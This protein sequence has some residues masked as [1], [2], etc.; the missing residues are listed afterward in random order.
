LFFIFGLFYDFIWW[1]RVNFINGLTVV[2]P[3]DAKITEK[4][5]SKELEASIVEKW[6]NENK[7]AFKKIGKQDYRMKILPQ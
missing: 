5:W 7:Y 4:R 2:L 3:M 6:K 1:S